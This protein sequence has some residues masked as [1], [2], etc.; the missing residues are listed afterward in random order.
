MQTNATVKPLPLTKAEGAKQPAPEQ[1]KAP[2]PTKRGSG[3]KTAKKGAKT[4][5][6]TD[7]D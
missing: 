1:A 4:A 7:K 6:K 2:A 5:K 3:A